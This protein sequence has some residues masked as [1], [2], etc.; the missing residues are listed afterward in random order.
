MARVF[1]A[2]YNFCKESDYKHMPPFF[3]AFIHGME[4]AGN[5]VVC[6]QTKQ[7]T[8][9]GYYKPIPRKVKNKLI[10]FNPDLCIFFNNT[11]WDVTGFLDCPILVYDVDSP[12]EFD[13]L[14]KIRNN[15]SRY[16]FIYNQTKGFLPI[17]EATGAKE[18]QGCY[19]PF[20]T[21]IRADESKKPKK[22]I[23]FV[24][25]NWLWKGFDFWRHFIWN[26][27]I[28]SDIKKAQEVVDYFTKYPFLPADE[29]YKILKNRPH[30]RIYFGDIRRAGIEISGIR[31]IK[32]L[33]A[34]SDMGLEINGSYWFGPWMSYFPKV[35]KC[36]KNKSVWTL[37]QNQELYNSSKIV[38][39]TKHVQAQEGFSFR[40]M[41][42]LASNACL[43]TE[44]SND[45]Q[46][47]FPGVEIPMFKT[48]EEEREI[49]QELLQNEEKRRELSMATQKIIDEKYR[50]ANV[51][52]TLEGFLGMNLQGEQGSL[53]YLQPW[54]FQK[55]SFFTKSYRRL[56]KI[57]YKFGGKH[58]GYDPYGRFE[59]SRYGLFRMMKELKISDVRTEI[60][61][62]FLPL[63]SLTDR[64]GVIEKKN[65]FF[66][67]TVNLFTKITNK[68][69]IMSKVAYFINKI[70]ML[71]PRP[72]TKLHKKINI[73]KMKSKVKK[74]EKVRV[75]L[76]VSRMSCWIYED[77]YRVLNES[78]EFEPIIV[79][80]PF[81][82]RGL[83]H[84]KECMND[85]YLELK[86]RGY[87]PIKGYDEET[88]S[89][90]DVRKKL[91]PDMVFFTK[92]WKRHFH[93]YFYISRFRDKICFLSDYAYVIH[94]HM[95]AVNFE[96]QNLV[97]V[98]FYDSQRQIEILSD[99]MFNKGKNLLSSGSLKIQKLFDKDYHPLESPWK[100]Q[101]RTKKKI[102]WAPH[103]ED[104]TGPE[105]YQFDSFYDLQEAMLKIADK[106]KDEIQIAFKPHPLL[107]VKL[108]EYWG[109]EAQ[110]EYYDEWNKK[111]NTQLEEGEFID[112][113]ITSD[114]MIMDCLSFIAEYSA[115]MKPTL[116]TI[117]SDSRVLLNE[118]GEELLEH[119]YVVENDLPDKVCDF[120]ENIVL[121]GNDV[122]YVERKK[123]VE[124]NL[125]PPNG[126]SA[127]E[128][129]YCKMREYVK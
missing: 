14:D 106:Y 26:N 119:M 57:V 41:D 23:V 34:V 127:A 9:R 6:F 87:S 19:I 1:I 94:G 92:F 107:K 75:V 109:E 10:K 55:I 30:R 116:F 66:E 128:N 44:Y 88:N 17:Q 121:T 114:A 24:G 100:V 32:Y 97:D 47:L 80:K 117:G 38:I 21:E 33:E 91:N 120:I 129:I 67:K 126:L 110:I 2:L 37:E 11:F 118:M 36:V 59:V 8:D 27:P 125:L 111:E 45:L 61:C 53:V 81:M 13:N 35:M 95:E 52:Q 69:Q 123:Y 65:L 22:N 85:T 72:I 115:T 64:K 83:A 58:F 112:L 43:V 70:K 4:K 113:F 74:G 48:P 98:Y 18:E 63:Y 50:F 82:S 28:D 40:V 105:Q 124:E 104:F 90:L 20:F 31:R 3:E 89:Y 54:K 122:K 56:Q 51:R 96:I 42:I 99:R 29:I 108:I 5:N 77:L 79:V 46:N 12:N 68:L 86:R 49:C 60:Y 15:L 7:T 103:H 76:F 71:R 102:I 39:N 84:M 93:K 78:E 62:L 101:N 73:K 16:K 25:T